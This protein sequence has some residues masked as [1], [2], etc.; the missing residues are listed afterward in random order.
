MLASGGRSLYEAQQILGHFDPKDT[1]RY[2]HLSSK[3]LQ[4]AANADSVIVARV[5]PKAA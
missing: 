5:E 2:A 4:E 3:T 1:M